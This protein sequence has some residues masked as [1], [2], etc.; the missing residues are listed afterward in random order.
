MEKRAN[1]SIEELSLQLSFSHKGHS[2]YQAIDEAKLFRLAK[3]Y[4]SPNGEE[5]WWN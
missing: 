5:I 3:D 1:I 4:M 2:T